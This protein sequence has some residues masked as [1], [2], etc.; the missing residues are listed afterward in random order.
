MIPEDL[1]TGLPLM[2]NIQ[3]HINLIPS[4]SLPNLPHYRMSSGENKILREKIEE[5]LNK[6]HIQVNMSTCVVPTLLM[7]KKDES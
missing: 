3:H 1:P 2:H 6:G 5:S 7:P 4:S